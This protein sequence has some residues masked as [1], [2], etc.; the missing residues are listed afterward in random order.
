LTNSPIVGINFNCGMTYKKFNP[1]K[2]KE[3]ENK[4]NPTETII[5]H[6]LIWFMNFLL[7]LWW[8][9]DSYEMYALIAAFVQVL[10]WA[11]LFYTVRLYV[12][13]KYLWKN[14]FKLA[15]SFLLIYIIFQVFTILY[16][17]FLTNIDKSGSI[18][19]IMHIKRGSFWY[20]NISFVAFGFTYYDELGKEK[21]KIKKIELKL[22]NAELENLK[23]Q[24]TPHFLFNSLWYI[25]T[26]VQSQGNEKATKA[27]E[28]L[29]E[30][31]RYSMQSR[32][33]GEF[34]PLEDELNY[35]NNFI[36]L[37]RLRVPTIC[38][39]YKVEKD[40][41]DIKILPLVMM[42]FVEN[43]FKHGQIHD[44]ANPL[45]IHLTVEKN[46][47]F[48][49][50]VKNKISTLGK[51][52]SSGIGLEN[53]KSRLETAYKEKYKLE[54]KNDSIFYTTKLMIEA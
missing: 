25:Y 17:D 44:S 21:E 31:M 30:M 49:F 47:S 54:I 38:L 46:K 23:A 12:Y 28:L 50:F 33:V 19:L 5:N 1:T 22:K 4:N 18:P 37:Q 14:H 11:I 29:S 36:E 40:L 2:M 51:E 16:T 20:F 6:C 52:R 53:V 3:L 26:L 39:D 43:A 9:F 32:K 35:V 10:S 42:S 34:V 7:Q 41:K 13:P 8:R 48:T 24:Y 45:T 27:V 15:L